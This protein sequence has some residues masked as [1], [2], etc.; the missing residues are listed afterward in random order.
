MEEEE[1]STR[2]RRSDQV[3]EYKT[4][5]KRGR[6]GQSDAVTT[7]RAALRQWLSDDSESHMTVYAGSSRRSALDRFGLLCGHLDKLLNPQEALSPHDEK[8]AAR[9]ALVERDEK[10]LIMRVPGKSGSLAIKYG[11]ENNN[12][13]H[14]SAIK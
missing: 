4:I 6:V 1:E 8:L 10:N 9:A 13:S 3:K 7:T 11:S 14:S 2:E 12:N 5:G